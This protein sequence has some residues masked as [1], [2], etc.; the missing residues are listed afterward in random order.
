VSDPW[1]IPRA[2]H[3]ETDDEIIF[4]AV[5]R[6][7]SAW[8]EAEEAIAYLFAFFVEAGKIDAPALRAY[9]TVFGVKNRIK[10]VRHAADAWFDDV[11]C[12]PHK[13][14]PYSA[15][16]ACEHWADRRN[17]LA[18]GAVDL[19]TDDLPAG[20]FLFPGYFT[21]KRPMRGPALFRY[22][23]N[24]INVLAENFGIL[25]ERLKKIFDELKEWRELPAART[26]WD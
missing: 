20:W 24:Q 1:E 6:A 10:M 3:G 18:H 26:T 19:S 7:L 23:A 15:L 2:E 22:N 13:C 25:R 21:K 14:N 5:G 12:C 11:E 8:T 16:R 17:D 9:S 4:T